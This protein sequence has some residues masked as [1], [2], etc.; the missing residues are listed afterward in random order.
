MLNWD[1]EKLGKLEEV[2]CRTFTVDVESFGE[3]HQEEL[4]PD[5]QSILVT[6]NNITEFVRL[7]I[8]F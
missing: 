3:I 1:E 8:D 7:Y 5:G 6:K 2:M 4:K